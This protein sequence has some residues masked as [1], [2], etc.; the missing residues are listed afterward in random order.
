[1]TVPVTV[2]S[3]ATVIVQRNADNNA[4]GLDIDWMRVS[5]SAA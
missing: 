4:N 5:S 2:P 1:V 3:G